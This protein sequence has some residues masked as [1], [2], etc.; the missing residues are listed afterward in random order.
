MLFF[1]QTYNI[2]EDMKTEYFILGSGYFKRKS[3]IF[4]FWETTN[5]AQNERGIKNDWEQKWNNH[6]FG[7]GITG[8]GTGETACS[9]WKEKT[10]P[11]EGAIGSWERIMSE[12]G[13]WRLRWKSF[14]KNKVWNKY[15]VDRDK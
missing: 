6:K 8:I 1:C 4:L 11:E 3:A 13:N 9:Q 2:K 10:E 14:K 15:L 5:T 12:Y 7:K